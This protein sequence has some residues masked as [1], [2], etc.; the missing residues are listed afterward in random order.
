MIFYA[1]RLYISCCSV[2]T[3]RTVYSVSSV[4]TVA[5]LE[6]FA[7]FR[8]VGTVLH[9][10][11]S[12]FCCTVRTTC[13][14]CSGCL[15]YLHCLHCSHCLKCLQCLQCLHCFALFALFCTSC[16]VCSVCTVC[17]VCT[18]HIVDACHDKGSSFFTA[19]FSDRRGS[20]IKDLLFL[21]SLNLLITPRKRPKHRCLSWYQSSTGS[22]S[23]H[24]HGQ[25]HAVPHAARILA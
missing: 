11:Q 14:V 21:I 7:L 8:S 17:T 5:L 1:L 23:A 25:G 10:I 4:R 19:L 3:F 12:H 20:S 22:V 24:K 18:V 13:S 9:C 16:N 15:H 6:L 2:C